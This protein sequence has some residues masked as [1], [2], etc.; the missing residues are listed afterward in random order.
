MSTEKLFKNMNKI[1]KQLKYNPIILEKIIQETPIYE[2][3]KNLS[4]RIDDICLYQDEPEEELDGN[5]ENDFQEISKD[6]T[7]MLKRIDMFQCSSIL[8]NIRKEII[9]ISNKILTNEEIIYKSKLS[10]LFDLINNIEIDMNEEEKYFQNNDYNINS[11][12][13]N[14]LD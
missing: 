13:M 12:R 3:W 2:F 14:E 11:N 1:Y 5:W 6:P 8:S 7:G 9:D 10:F 4:T